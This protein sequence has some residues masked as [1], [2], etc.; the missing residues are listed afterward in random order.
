MIGIATLAALTSLF[1]VD[2]TTS[3][4][5]AVRYQTWEGWG[6]SLCWWANVIG[7][8]PE[9]LRTQLT[10]QAIGGLQLNIVRYNIGGG[11]NPEMQTMEPRAR[12]AG[13]LRPDGTYDW[14]AD[15]GQRWV[16]NR[17]IQQGANTF[18][19]FS[20]SPPYFM[21]NS[22]SATGAVGGGDN[23]RPDRVRAFADYLATVVKRFRDHW[24]VRFD[25]LSPMNEPVANWWTYGGRQEG[26]H[27]S[28]GPRQSEL[29][30]AVQAAL[31]AKRLP[32]LIT[33][34]EESINNWAVSSWDA[35]RP[36]AKAAIA[37]LHTHCYGGSAQTWVNHRAARDGKGLWMS[38]Y[39]DGDATGMTM[40]RQ[41]VL[42]LK[43]M[44]PT[45]WVYWQVIDGGSGWGGID[46][47]LNQRATDYVVNRKYHVL[48]QFTRWIRPGAVF[49]PV[50]DS[51]TVA[52]LR[53]SKLVLV[54]VASSQRTVRF[55]LSRFG[56]V[57]SSVKAVRTSPTENHATLT[58]IPIAGA[59]FEAVLPADSVTTFE[60][61]GCQYAGPVFSG[62]YTMASGR[63]GKRLEVPWGAQDQGAWLGTAPGSAGLEQQ[64][65]VEGRGDGVLKFRNRQTGRYA[66]LWDDE[67]NKYPLLQW[68]DNSDTTLYWTPLVQTNGHWRLDSVRRA[69]EALVEN[70]TPGNGWPDVGVYPW[71]GG[72]EQTWKLE[73]LPGR[74]RGRG[75]AR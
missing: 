53:G 65:H 31:K 34:T 24:G 8:Y 59:R 11:E 33:G 66:A 6:T 28:A 36:E 60:I 39:G 37:R 45:A 52:A 51:G 32:T 9:P 38:E 74:N 48:A 57:G 10:D 73:A 18:E 25:T 13:F 70:P 47:D 54:S 72:A 50:D 55:D 16:L 1:P 26:C 44:M 23:L 69:G 30:L 46:I 14:T 56:A 27:V 4:D 75:A 67:P 63:T 7:T 20:N 40:A 12:M 2:A 35:L 29:I 41:I 22:G 3:V 21:T 19:A 43:V 58:P 15:P 17:A 5:P 62:F 49:V 71:Y 61:E 68:N 64:W 42:D